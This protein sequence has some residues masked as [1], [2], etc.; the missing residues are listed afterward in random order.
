M[1][2]KHTWTAIRIGETGFAGGYDVYAVRDANNRSI[3]EGLTKEQ[4]ELLAAAP[5]L[6]EALTKIAEMDDESNE[7]DGAE[8]YTVC[9]EIARAAL[10]TGEGVR[11]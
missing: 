5:A 6:V 10:A 4:A 9:R 11:K 3:A 1:S 2:A 7:W 8:K